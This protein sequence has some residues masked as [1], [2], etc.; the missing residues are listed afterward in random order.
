VI[1]RVFPGISRNKFGSYLTF[2]AVLRL[3]YAYLQVSDLKASKKY[4]KEALKMQP[5]QT[6]MMKKVKIANLNQIT[7]M[8]RLKRKKKKI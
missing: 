3:G 5:K 7:G 6:M 4:Y 8:K 2:D 1:V